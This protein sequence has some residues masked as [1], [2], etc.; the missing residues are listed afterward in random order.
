[1]WGSL[2]RPIP[3]VPERPGVWDR[4]YKTDR[5]GDIHR[6]AFQLNSDRGG[7]FRHPDLPLEVSTCHYRSGFV[8]TAAWAYMGWV[9]GS[10]SPY[11]LDAG[12]VVGAIRLLIRSVIH[13]PGPRPHPR[14]LLNTDIFT[15]HTRLREYPIPDHAERIL[16]SLRHEKPWNAPCHRRADPLV[17]RTSEPFTRMER[18]C[19]NRGSSSS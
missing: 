18:I 9:V 2:I 12:I 16:Y 7:I 6:M 15:P 19:A 11:G 5:V 17:A 3:C 14:G 4:W 10:A 13:L 8:L 1:M